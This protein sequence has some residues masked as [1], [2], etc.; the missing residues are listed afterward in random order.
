MPL[1]G[2]LTVIVLSAGAF[3]TALAAGGENAPAPPPPENL[4]RKARVRAT[5]E[6]SEHYL[7]K[8]AADGKVP[9]PGSRAD[10]DQAWCVRGEAARDRAELVFEWD[11][12]VPIAEVVYYARTAWF[13][14]EGWKDY[15]IHLDG[16]AMPAASGMLILGHGP[17]RIKIPRARAA[18]L[19][20]RF[21]CSHGGLNPG[22]SEVEIFPES[23]PEGA[24]PRFHKLRRGRPQV[25][26]EYLSE[27]TRLISEGKL[28]FDRLLFLKRQE[29][30]PSHVY[31]ACCE[32]FRPGGGLYLLSPPRPGGAVT[33]LLASPEGQ[34]LDLDLSCDG[35]EIVFS[36][37]KE[38][39][40]GYHI[41]RIGA[42]GAGLVQL[43]SGAW[44]DYNACWLPDGGIAF[45]STRAS[46]NVLCFHTP[47]GVLYRM[48]RDGGG[49]KRLSANYVNDFTPS[50]LADGRILYSRWEYVDRPAIP[51]QSLWAIHPDGTGLQVF[52]G[53]RVLSPASFLEARA[54]PGTRKV[55]C[56]L[57]SHNGPIRGAIGLIDP[58][59]G[60]NA[61]EAIVNLTPEV[62]IGRVDQGDGNNVH[63]PY[64]TPNP[65]DERRFLVSRDGILLLGEIGKGFAEIYASPDGLGCYDGAN[66]APRSA[67][68]IMAEEI[69]A[70][71][72][73]AAESTGGGESPEEATVF[74]VD[75][76]R[77]LE[78]A[79][80]RGA[81]K[82]LR[83]VEEVAKPLRTAARG[84]GFQTPVISCGAT[85][86]VKRVWGSVPVG[87]D[88][89]ACFKVP[90]GRPLYFLAADENGMAVQRMRSFAHF[91]PGEIR[92]CAGCH[93]NSSGLPPARARP[94]A[95]LHPPRALEPPAYGLED[96][97]Y[98]AI[99]QPVLDRHC[100]PC[101]NGV[102]PQG[103][104]DLS[105]DQ[106]DWFNVSYDVLT[107]GWV[108]WIDTRNGQEA[109]ILQTAP[110]RWGAPASRLSKLLLDGHPDRQGNPRLCLDRESRERIFT[111]IDLNVPYYG[112]YEMAD[113]SLPGG[114]RLYPEGLDDRL[115][116][117]WKSRCAGCHA[118]KRMTPG[119]VRIAR[120]EHNPF[121]LAPLAR[122]AG[123]R[124]AC[125]APVFQSREDPDYR[126]LLGLFEPI[127]EALR[128]TPRMDMP[129][130]RPALVSRSRL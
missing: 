86:A 122:S 92:G 127:E 100:A 44:H 98:S 41:F 16:A 83:V 20:I 85:Y 118:A 24:L 53:N 108:S 110:N 90:A 103:G 32:D 130:A 11:E 109:N 64:E 38:V 26:P 37:R 8:F 10:L 120:P 105:G 116:Q 9:D 27:L 13:S 78:P 3:G 34:I 54:I 94:E 46:S 93:E 113:E 12:A 72:P 81:V 79:V 115:S 123:G 80:P 43:S 107:R 15:E 82:A 62:D 71:K 14:E 68:A 91:Q 74:V 66:T 128:K 104:I 70:S 65:I 96:F 45:I 17:Q 89:S 29:L 117:V 40:C 59:L 52:F 48:D 6:Y 2:W 61:Q 119:F 7:A 77:G 28:G 126:A 76:Y 88:G 97:D 129:G 42:D 1:K 87:E 25:A 57:T 4:A 114:R 36:W 111:W 73:A 5:S 31:T 121:L 101:H 56:T 21:L 84:F 99:V 51:I 112:T 55:L 102:D 75:V 58:A 50:V 39:G 33:E 95:L 30:N 67:P 22:A 60:V 23:P 19:A 69:G 125:S 49:L 18:K 124:G 63:G 106:T 47:S 35:K